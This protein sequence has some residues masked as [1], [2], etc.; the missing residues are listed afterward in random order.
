MPKALFI[1]EAV[2]SDNELVEKTSQVV[3]EKQGKKGSRK[4]DPYFLILAK[5]QKIFN[6]QV[7]IARCGLYGDCVRIALFKYNSKV[8]ESENEFS[9]RQFKS[10]FT[11]YVVDILDRKSFEKQCKLRHAEP[12]IVATYVA[13][14]TS[15]NRKKVLN[16]S[17]GDIPQRFL[18]C[19]VPIFEI[20]ELQ[21]FDTEGILNDYVA[22][23]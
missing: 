23:K 20:E 10:R 8:R 6:E 11:E 15:E 5:A 14:M 17:W 9:E 7:D 2:N 16:G 13:T 19:G 4:K 3:N 22:S 1:S 18:D 12:Y 21:E